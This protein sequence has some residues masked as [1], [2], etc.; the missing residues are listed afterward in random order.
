MKRVVFLAFVL[1]IAAA[2][3]LAALAA[4]TVQPTPKFGRGTL[5]ITQNERRVVL[6]VEIAESMEARSYGLMLRKSLPDNAGMLFVFEEDGKWGFWMKNTLIP[7]SIGFID[8]AWRLL[9]V[10]DMAVAD[11]PANGPFKIY[12]SKEAY[13]YALE[14][15]QGFF[16]RRG[17]TAG[18]QLKLTK[19]P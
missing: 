14:V 12:E 3:T 11:D 7:L 13:R 19:N 6:S 2:A 1:A 18:A 10:A 4:P 8:K 15:N 5:T 17:I 16:Q 9:E